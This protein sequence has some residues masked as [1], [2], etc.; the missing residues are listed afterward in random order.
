MAIVSYRSTASASFLGFPFAWIP[1]AIH[2]YSTLNLMT[3]LLLRRLRLL[4]QVLHKLRLRLLL[5]RRLL[6]RRSR[7]RK[8]RSQSCNLVRQPSNLRLMLLRL[9]RDP[10]LHLSNIAPNID[11]PSPNHIAHTARA[12][13]AV[14]RHAALIRLHP[15]AGSLLVLQHAGAGFSTLLLLLLGAFIWHGH[16]HVCGPEAGQGGELH[17]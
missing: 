6:L 7:L 8:L 17:V 9:P 1:A 16:A 3:S 14:A 4:L 5:L 2:N 13:G 12:A 10:P 15:R 11:L